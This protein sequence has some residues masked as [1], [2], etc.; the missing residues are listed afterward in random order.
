MERKITINIKQNNENTTSEL[1]IYE[2][3][4]E[5]YNFNEETFI[6]ELIQSLETPKRPK[7][8]KDRSESNF[9]KKPNNK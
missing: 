9:Q 4:K 1:L 3:G 2:N 7:F 8:L 5:I 6:K